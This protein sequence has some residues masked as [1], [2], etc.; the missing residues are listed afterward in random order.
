MHSFLCSD[1]QF[2]VH[3]VG[4]VS[5][6]AVKRY[7]FWITSNRVGDPKRIQGVGDQGS[8]VGDQ[9]SGFRDQSS[10]LT[11]FLDRSPQLIKHFTYFCFNPKHFVYLVFIDII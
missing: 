11:S 6:K 2:S 10:G 8:G 9:V 1:A 4:V 3:K 7:I 5:V